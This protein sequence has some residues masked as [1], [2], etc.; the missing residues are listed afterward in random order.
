MMRY[1]RDSR[2]YAFALGLVE[3]WGGCGGRTHA[4]SHDWNVAYDRGMNLADALRGRSD[5]D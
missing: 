5:N 4:I 2:A 1:I 3:H